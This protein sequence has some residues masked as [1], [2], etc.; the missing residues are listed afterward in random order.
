[1]KKKN[2]NTKKQKGKKKKKKEKKKKKKKN[3]KYSVRDSAKKKD[4]NHVQNGGTIRVMETG[5]RKL[6]YINKTGYLVRRQL[7]IDELLDV[8]IQSMKTLTRRFE[9]VNDKDAARGKWLDGW[10]VM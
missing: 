10:R 5:K 2:K 6:N 3:T 8:K 4:Q 9:D 7:G 1:M